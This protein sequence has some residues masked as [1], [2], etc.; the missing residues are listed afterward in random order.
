MR[1]VQLRE[2]ASTRKRLEGDPS[3]RLRLADAAPAGD[4]PPP[5]DEC[6]YAEKTEV[7]NELLRNA[8]AE[9]KMK[10]MAV[11]FAQDVLQHYDGQV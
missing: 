2:L 4:P 3:A 11:Q 10:T 6:L 9:L 8:E 5:A 1:D 7:V